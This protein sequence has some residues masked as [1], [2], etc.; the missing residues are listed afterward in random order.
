MG[1][2]PAT[3]DL[4]FAD[5]GIDGL[6]D[7][8]IPVSVDT[9]NRVTLAQL[10]GPTLDF[11]FSDNYTEYRTGNVIG[12]LTNP[13]LIAFQPL[14]NPQTGSKS[15]GPSGLAFSPTNFPSP[16]ANGV[17][18]GFH[19]R[20]DS[21]GVANDENPVIFVDLATNQYFHFIDNNDPN[22]GHI[23]S[24]F[25]TADSLFLADFASTNGGTSGIVYQI[26][27]VPE[28]GTLALSLTALGIVWLR[29]LR[30]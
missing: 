28:P 27:A 13:P 21:V 15:E 9:L 20:Q 19:G 25:S 14:G 4:Y 12:T 17:F 22:V 10:P 8:N 29:R 7:A 3:G 30:G 2:R 5:N 23:D 1:F 6:S 16:L 26:S 11:G 18:I 24:L